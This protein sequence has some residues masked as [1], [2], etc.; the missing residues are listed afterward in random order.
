[1]LDGPAL[2]IL[3]IHPPGEVQPAVQLDSKPSMQLVAAVAHELVKELLQ[4]TSDGT[5]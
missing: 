5:A 1:M 4:E 2:G 3:A